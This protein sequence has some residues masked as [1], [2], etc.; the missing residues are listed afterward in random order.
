M[1]LAGLPGTCGVCD[2]P[3]V[4]GQ[5]LCRACLDAQ[6]AAHMAALAEQVRMARYRLEHETPPLCATCGHL[7]EVAQ[8]SG[9]PVC[10]GCLIGDRAR[11]ESVEVA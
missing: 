8:L 5:E 10:Y 11:P 3:A 1:R 4:T 7:Y 9:E 2:L 6:T